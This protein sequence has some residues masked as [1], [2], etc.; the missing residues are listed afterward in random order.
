MRQ[1]CC[2][3]PEAKTQ[4]PFSSSTF[5]RSSD[6]RNN[7]G[8]VTVGTGGETAVWKETALHSDAKFEI[9]PILHRN[10]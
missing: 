9:K 1:T 10:N 2:F 5:R 4:F 3:D 8:I 6:Y 7:D